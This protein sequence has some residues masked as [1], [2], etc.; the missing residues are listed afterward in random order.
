MEYSD[1]IFTPIDVPPIPNKEKV[2]ERFNAPD[3]YI[4]WD[5]ETLLGEKEYN[6]PLGRPQKWTDAARQN[7]SELINWIESYLP[8]DELYYI[9]IARA[10][11]EIP[12]HIDGN[13]VEPTHKHHL[14]ILPETL[15]YCLAHEPIGYRFVI[16]GSKDKMY[17]CK[18]Y[19]YTRDMTW[20]EK[21]YCH[22]PD[23]TDCF[24]IRN[25]DQ[26]HGV[27][28]DSE[29]RLIGFILG[30]VNP[31]KHKDL[32]NQSVNKYAHNVIRKQDVFDA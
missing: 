17:M 14:A 16:A 8:F 11:H 29:D 21:H 30:K 31:Q 6:N 19:D 12:P 18:E 26:P 10:K 2:L 7:Y 32:I 23:E 9:R 5:E 27:E 3:F 13:A 24:L 1:I 15:E 20:Q 22:V 25:Q 28:A 4:W